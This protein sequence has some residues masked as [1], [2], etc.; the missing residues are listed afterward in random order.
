M[1]TFKR[2]Y[3]STSQLF[4]AD[5]LCIFWKCVCTL[6]SDKHSREMLKTVIQNDDLNQKPISYS[7][8]YALL[9]VHVIRYIIKKEYTINTLRKYINRMYSRVYII[10]VIWTK[11]PTC[12]VTDQKK[13]PSQV[14][15][16]IPLR[17]SHTNHLNEIPANSSITLYLKSSFKWI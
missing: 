7:R 6:A 14:I 10:I 8:K 4:L 1:I 5:M 15:T 3:L 11:A 16:P 2:A 9:Q 13:I 17:Q 12:A